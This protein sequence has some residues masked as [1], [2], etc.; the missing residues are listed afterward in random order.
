MKGVKRFAATFLI[1]T[2]LVLL[3]AEGA[4]AY[5]LHTRF[6]LF[7]HPCDIYMENISFE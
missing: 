7:G 2:G 1:I 5:L 3:L 4:Y 6:E